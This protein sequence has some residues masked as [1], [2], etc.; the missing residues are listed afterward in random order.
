MNTGDRSE[1]HAGGS[2]WP[3][4]GPR[5]HC[6]PCG[7]LHVQG[8]VTCPDCLHRLLPGCDRVGWLEKL[9]LSVLR[10]QGLMMQ[11]RLL[12]HVLLHSQGSHVGHSGTSV[13]HGLHV[14][15]LP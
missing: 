15:L 6:I 4:C 13:R 2:V 1:A 10:Q 9:L 7:G 11:V 12:C 8:A 14:I 5:A 3:C